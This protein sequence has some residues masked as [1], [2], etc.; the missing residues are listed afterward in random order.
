MKEVAKKRNK[1]EG[2]KSE[3]IAAPNIMSNLF[4][5]NPV[6]IDL[7]KSVRGH[8]SDGDGAADDDG[9]SAVSSL[10]DS[11][12]TNKKSSIKKGEYSHFKKQISSKMPEIKEIVYG[13]QKSNLMA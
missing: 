2:P 9:D 8:S 3:T 4:F 7:H 11:P 5:L 1:A 12:S 13:K 6:I 10:I